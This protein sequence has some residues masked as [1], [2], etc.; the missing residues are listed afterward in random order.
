MSGN[1]EKS[2]KNGKNGGYSPTPRVPLSTPGGAD[3]PILDTSLASR[4][5]GRHQVCLAFFHGHYGAYRSHGSYGWVSGT[6][7]QPALSVP[8]VSVPQFWTF[9]TCLVQN[10]FSKPVTNHILYIVDRHSISASL[11]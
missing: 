6:S 2:E 5:R 3:S 10:H 1:T 7:P 8:S 11:R 4:I 9:R